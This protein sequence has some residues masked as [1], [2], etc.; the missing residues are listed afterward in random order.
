MEDFEQYDRALLKVVAEECGLSDL[1]LVT[2][3]D[4]GHTDPMLVLPYGVLAE[5]DCD[6]QQVSII[7]N[8]VV[9]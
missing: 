6:R 1:A 2:R 8:A 4:F 9:D 7:E 3:M 5:I